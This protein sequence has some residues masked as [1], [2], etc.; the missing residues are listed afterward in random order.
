M[1][2]SGGASGVSA[3]RAGLG[4]A[5]DGLV[6][7]WAPPV[8]AYRAE[9]LPGP[10]VV[11]A[12]AAEQV[13]HLTRRTGE[14]R[15]L[16]PAVRGALDGAAAGRPRGRAPWRRVVVEG[17]GEGSGGARDLAFLMRRDGEGRVPGGLGSGHLVI[18]NGTRTPDGMI[19]RTGRPLGDEALVVVMVGDF[20]RRPPTV[21]QLQALTELADYARA[22]TGVI[23]V[24]LGDLAR[25]PVAASVLEAA[26]PVGAGGHPVVET[27]RN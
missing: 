2:Q 4:V 24:V 7:G 19:E 1:W 25:A 8:P 26:F 20:S 27:A 14:W 11:A 15:F 22:K 21:A 9:R 17:T 6:E 5:G 13:G 16:T 18:G 3:A 23:P 10:P 12:V